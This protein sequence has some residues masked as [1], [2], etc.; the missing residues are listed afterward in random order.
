M[1]QNVGFIGLG[2]MGLPMAI[3]LVKAGFSVKGSDLSAE[4]VAK[5]T[6]AGGQGVGSAAEAVEGAE[7]IVTMLPAG[8]HVRAVYEEAILGKAAAGTLLIDSSTIDVETA[9]ALANE[10]E[11]VGLEM[12][13]A[14]VS[15]GTV[16]AQGGTLTFMVGGKADSLEK[17]RAVLE[18]MGKNIVLAGD[19]GAGQAVKACNNMILAV[20][21]IGVSEGLVMAEKLGVDLQRVY[22]ICSTSTS[23]CWALNT[24]CPVPGMSEAAPSNRDFAPGFTANMMLK[25]LKL[26][27]DAAGSSATTTEIG[28]HALALYQEFVDNGNGELDF[29]GI[30]RMIRE[31]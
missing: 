17:G 31:R 7:I 22:D 13:D 3:N 5:L 28:K 23:S 24:Y 20:S 12:L 27:Q 8:R 9:R 15:G 25:D 11:A 6:E 26:A 16:G 4:Q 18:V 19:A 2:N 1:T 21:M 30:I 10:A 29:S 14:P